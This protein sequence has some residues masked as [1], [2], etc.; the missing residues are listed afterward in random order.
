MKQIANISIFNDLAD[1]T[2]PEPT[3]EH[4]SSE[5]MIGNNFEYYVAGKAREIQTRCNELMHQLDSQANRWWKQGAVQKR[6]L[7][8]IH[9]LDKEIYQLAQQTDDDTP[10]L[11]A[12]FYDA[13][14]AHDALVNRYHQVY[15]GF[16][17][18][19]STPPM[20]REAYINRPRRATRGGHQQVLGP[21]H[22]PGDVDYPVGYGG[23]LTG[24]PRLRPTINFPAIPETMLASAA[25]NALV[26]AHNNFREWYQRACAFNNILTMRQEHGLPVSEPCKKALNLIWHKVELPVGGA[27]QSDM[28]E[29]MTGAGQ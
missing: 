16:S 17:F 11:R 1:L 12:A 13:S 18:K 23:L 20:S 6:V 28:M 19:E 8:N 7:D 22:S 15:D 14:K 27:P 5:P 9:S 24:Q 3:G 4:N 25:A 10:A 21:Q 29:L 26:K 2:G